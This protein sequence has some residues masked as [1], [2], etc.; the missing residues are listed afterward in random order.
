MGAIL[1]ILGSAFS[2]GATGLIGV[3]LQRV[4]DWL[5]VRE[6]TRLEDLKFKNAL[7]MR[8]LDIEMSKQEWAARLSIAST[9]AEAKKDVAESEAF[10]ASLIKEPERYSNA[11]AVTPG[12]NWLLVLLDLFRGGIRPGLTIYLCVV[13]TI[14]MKTST[15]LVEKE[16][17]TPEEALKMIMLLIDAI[18]YVWTTCTLWWFG[19]R[20]K[21]VKQPITKV[22]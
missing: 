8:K 1:G 16:D 7:E 20:N 3:L 22:G 19:T 2:G 13:V 11:A 21:Q 6:Q 10:A 4:F 14:L 5:H 9:E 12:Q 18:I 17:L 15:S